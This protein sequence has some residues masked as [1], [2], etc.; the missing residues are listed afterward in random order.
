MDRLGRWLGHRGTFCFLWVRQ[1][2]SVSESLLPGDSWRCRDEGMEMN[3]GQMARG[4]NVL[5][6]TDDTVMSCMATMY[7]ALYPFPNPRL[8]C[9]ETLWTIWSNGRALKVDK[10]RT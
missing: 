2:T 3:G 10:S 9:E 8:L 1:A 6:G 4:W 5:E 7:D